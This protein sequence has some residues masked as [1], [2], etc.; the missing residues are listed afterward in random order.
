MDLRVYVARRLAQALPLIFVLILFTFFVVHLAPGDPVS[1]MLSGATDVP[2][3]VLRETRAKLGLD[4]PL[5]VQLWIYLQ[6]LAVGNWGY[7]YVYSQP[8]T[9]ILIPR[10]WNT[11]FISLMAFA[12]QVS[13]GLFLGV[14]AAIKVG[15]KRDRILNITS[16]AIWS[17]PT[18]WV[19]I[20]LL[21]AFGV[22]IRI[23]PVAGMTSL[24]LAPGWFNYARD[25]A[26]HAA[27]PVITLA[28]GGFG[29]YF[30]LT[31]AGMLEVL[32]QDYILTAWS[33]G[34]APRTVY[35]KHAFRNALLPLVTIIASNAG[36]LLT[37]AA[38]IEVIYSWPGVGF[39]LYSSIKARDYQM[40]QLIFVM[41]G[42]LII[43][44]NLIADLL[45]AFLDPRVRY[46]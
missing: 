18:F 32:R 36:F 6:N 23:F 40:I 25:L 42:S 15:N 14:V 17:L 7:S 2:P 28:L 12:I 29:L 16:I 41:V 37:G 4:Q 22:F 38:L 1:Y 19:G 21:L 45:Y 5:Q 34:S 10:L 39:L 31:R 33:K 43:I 8:V 30:R 44:A 11:L 24:E 27:L 3:E 46:R 35:F 20:L 26:W 13:V 9:S